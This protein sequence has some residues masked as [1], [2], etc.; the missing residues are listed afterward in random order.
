MIPLLRHRLARPGKV[1]RSE[2]GN[3]F[4]RLK[5]FFLGLFRGLIRHLDPHQGNEALDGQ[6]KSLSPFGEKRLKRGKRQP[7]RVPVVRF[8]KRNVRK[9]P[10]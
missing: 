6:D 8:G 9:R 5:K 2:S 4:F 1:H 7:V 10:R 3:V